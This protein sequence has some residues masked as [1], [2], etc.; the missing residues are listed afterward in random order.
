MCSGQSIFQSCHTLFKLKYQYFRIK[1]KNK[2]KKKKA[3]RQC[4]FFFIIRDRTFKHKYLNFHINQRNKMPRAFQ[5]GDCDIFIFFIIRDK[6]FNINTKILIISNW[7]FKKSMYIYIYL[8]TSIETNCSSNLWKFLF[9]SDMNTCS[10]WLPIQFISGNGLIVSISPSIWPSITPP[11]VSP[12]TLERN[13]FQ[14]S[15]RMERY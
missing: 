1:Q 12:S 4:S 13:T 8:K 9:C 3:A 2:K 5:G 14:V 6:T 10:F 15:L 7:Y 11:S